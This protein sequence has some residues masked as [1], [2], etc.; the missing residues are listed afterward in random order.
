MSRKADKIVVKLLELKDVGNINRVNVKH[1][2][3]Q[4]GKIMEEIEV[5]VKLN[6]RRYCSTV[7]DLLDWAPMKTKVPLALQSKGKDKKKK[8]G[9]KVFT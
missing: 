9:M 1:A 4:R 8:T 3:G 5:F 2:L 6:T 7:I